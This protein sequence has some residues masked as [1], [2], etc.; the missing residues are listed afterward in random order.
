MRLESICIHVGGQDRPY[1][2]ETASTHVASLQGRKGLR[3]CK[4]LIGI[5]LL[6]DNI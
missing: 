3:T 1:S 5:K 6:Y 4:E 2:A